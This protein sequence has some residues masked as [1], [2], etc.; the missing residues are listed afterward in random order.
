MWASWFAASSIV[1]GKVTRQSTN[2]TSFEENG[3]LG[4]IWT[5]QYILQITDQVSYLEAKVKPFYMYF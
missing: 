1:E 5:F 2:A 4:R 3:E